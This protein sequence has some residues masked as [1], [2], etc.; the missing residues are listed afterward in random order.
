MYGLI[1][2]MLAA[3]LA[4]LQ[5]ATM[6]TMTQ[7]HQRSES[8]RRLDAAASFILTRLGTSAGTFSGST[9]TGIYA[10]AP[11]GEDSVL[12]S[13]AVIASVNAAQK[14]I[15]C[16]YAPAAVVEGTDDAIETLRIPGGTSYRI[17]RRI[18]ADGAFIVGSDAPPA[19]LTTA[20]IVPVAILI[21]PLTGKTPACA[22]VSVRKGVPWVQG[23]IVRVVTSTG[24]LL[25][26]LA[27][28]S[29]TPELYVTTTGSGSGRS[30]NDPMSL[31]AAIS[32]Y[33]Q[34]RPRFL[35]IRLT[36]GNYT[37]TELALLSQVDRTSSSS[38]LQ[39]VDDDGDTV[40]SPVIIPA[41]ST[42]LGI[43]T[44]L[45]IIGIN[46]GSTAPV[47]IL[48]GGRL[49]SINSSFG[50][51]VIDSGASATLTGTNAV[52]GMQV[53]GDLIVSGSFAHSGSLQL[54]V[55]AGGTATFAGT[56]TFATSAALPVLVVRGRV[57][58]SGSAQATSSSTTPV[59]IE[60]TGQLLI[61]ATFLVSAPSSNAAIL[62]DGGRLSVLAS[63]A[64]HRLGSPLALI[65]SIR[66]GEVDIGGSGLDA[67]GASTVPLIISAPTRL[68]GTA[69]LRYSGVACITQTGESAGTLGVPSAG[70]VTVESE[71]PFTDPTPG[72]GPTAADMA[73]DVVRQAANT[74][75]SRQRSLFAATWSCTS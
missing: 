56:S 18:T 47:R 20:G 2:I 62:V 3:V 10:L 72:D 4:P 54:L 40:V 6:F 24:S 38:T 59:S 14:I 67:S 49:S 57:A 69:S 19:A 71:T 58:L 70:G 60:P 43:A 34:A 45:Q 28:A 65:Q 22:D 48:S 41:T 50:L 68:S 73:A 52:G 32:Y 5:L 51:L 35:R 17:Q 53:D 23:G 12:P 13:G 63:G 8:I 39:I 46:F 1:G 11:D 27:D 44:D 42:V 26:T 31:S 30:R 61:D 75:R 37:G 9:D 25:S 15:Y 16:P 74:A 64:V 7:M 21:A 29:R 55:S 33:L 66:G 36:D